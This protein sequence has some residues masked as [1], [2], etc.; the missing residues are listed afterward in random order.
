MPWEVAKQTEVCSE[1]SRTRHRSVRPL[2]ENGDME[3]GV[4]DPS[5]TDHVNPLEK[6]VSD[7]VSSPAFMTVPM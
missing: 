4:R 7:T 6:S 1:L 2:A 5:D 3:N